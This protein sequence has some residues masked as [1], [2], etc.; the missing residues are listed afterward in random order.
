MSNVKPGRVGTVLCAHAVL[1][2]FSMDT[3]K[4]CPPYLISQQIN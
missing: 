2:P 3:M 1:Q 4:P